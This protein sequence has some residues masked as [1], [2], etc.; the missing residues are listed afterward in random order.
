MAGAPEERDLG[1][2]TIDVLVSFDGR[3]SAVASAVARGDYVFWLGS[4][5]SRSVVP[6][7]SELLRELLSFLQQRVDPSKEGC[8]FRKALNEILDISSIPQE[9]R[10][11]I[12]L[13]TAVGSWPDVDDLVL[14]LVNRYSTVLD[15]LVENEEPDFL[16]WEAIDVVHTYGSPDLEPAAEHLCLA[17]LMLEGVVRSALSAN[18]D[19]LIESA[20]ER[21]TG[22]RGA[23]LRV[24]VRQEE[25]AEPE[26]RCDLIK[27]HGCAVKA[28]ED[29]GTYRSALIARQSQ[30]SRWT[31]R[32][33]HSVMKGRLEDLAATRAALVV[34][35]S[36]Q[37]ANLHTIL[38]QA[39]EN[40]G[41]A[42]PV[43]PPA[44]VF[45]LERLHSDQKHVLRITYDESYPQNRQEIE[46]AA[47]LGAYAQ[48]LLL[49]LV[50]YTLTDKLCALIRSKPPPNWDDASV[51]TLE[52]GVRCLRDVV[53]GTADDDAAAFVDRFISTAGM[54]LS[55][56]RSESPPDS[57]GRRYQP[58]T[59]QPIA[60]A[61]LDPNI[62][63]DALGFL[64]VAA[65]L[66]G[67]GVAE[68]LWRLTA[69]DVH[70]LGEG[71]CTLSG[72]S[73]VSRVFLVRDS[74][75]LS[76]LE[77][78]GYVI[79]SDP[80]V[81]AIHAKKIPTPQARSPRVQYGRTGRQAAREVAIETVVGASADAD[82]LL[83]SFRQSANL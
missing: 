41:R 33:E 71:V 50:L 62:D 65:S 6:D 9:T 2:R 36:A 5:L 12:D 37:D 69:G 72:V 18:W 80:S 67:R 57:S 4:G 8:R 28:A 49:G 45:A 79:M 40:L 10:D 17:I 38:N 60:Q 46:E 29:P 23:F 19:G 34:G 26:A 74:G 15:V 73:G 75:V 27:F 66:L 16:V 55:T 61:V 53:G 39:S 78:R 44:V 77:A 54:V 51:G 3:L 1:A 52:D 7:V 83:A 56:F 43:D 82:G 42:W 76:Q 81:L 13:S 24:V 30:I 21:L 48:P 70:H 25:F 58:L 20:I 63:T 35:L 22:E 47:R 68:D 59:A 31:T 11:A 64:A 14:R 32:S